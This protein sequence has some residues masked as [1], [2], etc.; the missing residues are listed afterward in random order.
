MPVATVSWTEVLTAI[1]A[2]VA[3]VVAVIS[4]AATIWL[5]K[6]TWKESLLTAQ[7]QERL[8][9]HLAVKERARSE[10]SLSLAKWAGW[11]MAASSFVGFIRF[12]GEARVDGRMTDDEFRSEG[13]TCDSRIRA[14]EAPLQIRCYEKR[15][16][17]ED[18]AEARVSSAPRCNHE[19]TLHGGRV[20]CSRG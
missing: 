5:T 15:R 13:E 12:L 6:R 19:S 1:A 3:L 18:A 20:T 16:D 10:L 9:A 14:T 7:R 8:A 4:L 17:D 2:A 11:L